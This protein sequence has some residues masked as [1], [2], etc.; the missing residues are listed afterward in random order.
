MQSLKVGPNDRAA[1]AAI[2]TSLRRRAGLSEP[3]YSTR[4]IIDACFP[5]TVVTGRELPDGVHDVVRIDEAAFRSHRAP[6]VI[7]YRRGISSAEQRHAI[8]H[9]LAHIIFDGADELGCATYSADRE[10][11]CD[12][13]ADE[14]LVPA[15]R[16]EADVSS[17]IS[18]DPGREALLDRLD[19]LASRFNAPVGCIKRQLRAV[20]SHG[21]KI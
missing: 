6:H 18:L 17:W 20:R 3:A 16:L 14:M 9:A 13:F 19:Q 8:A 15:D 10:Q 21:F 12:N 7:V 1:L 11:R 4:K 2:A 5:G